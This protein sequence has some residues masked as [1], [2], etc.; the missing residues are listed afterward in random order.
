M[1]ASGWFAAPAPLR[2]LLTPDPVRAGLDL[3][4]LPGFAIGNLGLRGWTP[5]ALALPQGCSCW[6]WDP[7]LEERSEKNDFSFPLAR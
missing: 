3:F 7:D 5:A 2:W 1:L 4:L 6:Q